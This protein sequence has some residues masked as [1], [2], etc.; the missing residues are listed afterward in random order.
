MNALK[1]LSTHF[2]ILCFYLTSFYPQFNTAYAGDNNEQVSE[3]SE[4]T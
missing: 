2:I 3:A 1:R 4:T